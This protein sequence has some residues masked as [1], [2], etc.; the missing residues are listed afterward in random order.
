MDESE[1]STR[2]RKSTYSVGGDCV[3][4][5]VDPTSVQV[6]DSKT[7][8]MELTFTPAEWRAFLAGVKA[9]EADV[10]GD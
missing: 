9:G 10:D 8:R 1:S 4:W 7:P 2:W 5:R 6:R 3:E